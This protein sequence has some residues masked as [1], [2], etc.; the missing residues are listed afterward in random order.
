MVEAANQS[1]LVPSN[2]WEKVPT[3]AQ[4]P[5]QEMRCLTAA[6]NGLNNEAI[7]AACHL[8]PKSVQSHINNAVRRI[9]SLEGSGEAMPAYA[10]RE[11]VVKLLIDHGY[12]EPVQEV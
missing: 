8:K 7:A 5:E 6:V 2:K 3:F 12:F 4:L 11:T 1:A 10:P 9:R